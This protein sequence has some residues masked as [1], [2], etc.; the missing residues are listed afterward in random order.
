MPTKRFS[1]YC[2][3]CNKRIGDF[4]EQDKISLVCKHC[5]SEFTLLNPLRNLPFTLKLKKYTGKI[6][7]DSDLDDSFPQIFCPFDGPSGFTKL[8]KPKIN[9]IFQCEK[10]KR[11]FIPLFEEATFNA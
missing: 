3:S 10:C 4:H 7:F 6:S 1:L 2:I 11:H 5:N 8:Q 9:Y